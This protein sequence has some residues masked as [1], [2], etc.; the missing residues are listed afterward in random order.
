MLK[1]IWIYQ[2]YVLSFAVQKKFTMGDIRKTGGRRFDWDKESQ[3]VYGTPVHKVRHN[4]ETGLYLYKRYWRRR[5]G[6]R[7]FVY[8]VVEPYGDKR[9]YPSFMEFQNGYGV[10]ISRHD[11]LCD[12]KIEW[13]LNHG[14]TERYYPSY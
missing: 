1:K 11:R 14:M 8:E 10:S 13:Y 7:E 4:P 5:N 12:E 2:K 3:S 9:S 6:R